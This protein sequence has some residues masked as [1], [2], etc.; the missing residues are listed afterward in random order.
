[1]GEVPP[2]ESTAV[3]QPALPAP[4]PP[5]WGSAYFCRGAYLSALRSR[6]AVEHAHSAGRNFRRMIMLRDARLFSFTNLLDH[7]SR[8]YPLPCTA[9][10]AV[11]YPCLLCRRHAKVPFRVPFSLRASAQ[12]C[13]GQHHYTHSC[14]GR[15]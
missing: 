15:C 4:L 2:G 7:G 8:A 1:M 6:P 11:A 12:P 5:G 3:G 10:L 9:T 14:D 13:G